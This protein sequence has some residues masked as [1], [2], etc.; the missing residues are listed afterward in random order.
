MRPADKQGMSDCLPGGGSYQ[1]NWY[2][3]NGKG[4]RE[5][6]NPGTTAVKYGMDFANSAYLQSCAQHMVS[7][8]K[9][10]GADG[11]FLDGAPTST[12]W[13]QLPTPCAPA[14]P[15]AATCASDASFQNAMTAALAYVTSTLH[16]HG[17]LTF[18]NISGGNVTFCCGGGPAVW[19]RYV[20]QVDGAMQESWTYGTNHLPLPAT[21][22]QAGLANT[23]WSEAHGKYT[24]VNDDITHCEACSDY[25]LAAMMLV[26]GGHS[27]YDISNGIY[28]GTTNGVWWPSYST[29]QGVGAPLG[30]Y[31]TL[32]DG[33]MVRSFA[34]GSVVVNDTTSAISDP[35]Y[36]RVPATSAQIR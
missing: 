1:E 34:S 11:V 3:H 23:A 36:G 2:L 10:I 8:A 27:S 5:A 6:W 26:A 7:V 12:H 24:L 31:R 21:E 35:T 20:A 30:P 4:Q 13:A 14:P 22:V 15:A 9:A 28:T 18:V 17:L 32:A 16:A 33:L 25:G 29:A 19:Q